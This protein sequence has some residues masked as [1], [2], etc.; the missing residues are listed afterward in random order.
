MLNIRLQKFMALAT[1][2]LLVS[3]PTII[4]VNVFIFNRLEAFSKNF[5]NKMFSIICSA[6][7]QVYGN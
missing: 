4:D 7:V 6:Q 2:A 3:Y 5:T 1:K